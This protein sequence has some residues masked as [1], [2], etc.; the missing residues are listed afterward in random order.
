MHQ[1]TSDLSSLIITLIVILSLWTRFL[2]AITNAINNMTDPIP[3]DGRMVD[4]DS[5]PP[6][7]TAAA[8]HV[9][10]NPYKKRQV[11][12]NPMPTP[13]AP[14][15]ATIGTSGNIVVPPLTR[16]PKRKEQSKH[17]GAR[18]RSGRKITN[19]THGPLLAVGS[20]ENAYGILATQDPVLQPVVEEVT[21]PT[22]MEL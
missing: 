18:K 15:Q 21:I 20:I 19:Q 11:K 3:T 7:R 12:D 5:A 1:T 16:I 8:R 4:A 2:S 10:V 13:A 9:T 22:T 17:G 6:D 14:R